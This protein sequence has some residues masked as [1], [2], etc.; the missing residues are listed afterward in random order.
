M[1][2]RRAVRS[3]DA[4]RWPVAWSARL[5]KRW[6]PPVGRAEEGKGKRRVQLR[7]RWMVSGPGS[8][9]SVIAAGESL[10]ATA[11]VRALKRTSEGF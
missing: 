4:L 2:L 3:A 5:A 7:R 10:P 6:P 9:R 11:A 8:A 1:P